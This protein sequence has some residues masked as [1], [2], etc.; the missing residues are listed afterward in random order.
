MAGRRAGPLD[1][2]IATAPGDSEC[3]A[4]RR[5]HRGVEDC[6][7]PGCLLADSAVG[8]VEVG[9]DRVDEMDWGRTEPSE[10][11]YRCGPH[12]RVPD[13]VSNEMHIL[14]LAMLGQAL[15]DPRSTGTQSAVCCESR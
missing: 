13:L 14:S 4:V 8:V 2:G 3:A 15:E 6:H 12:A 7:G 5:E 9:L 11:G 1:R 10:A